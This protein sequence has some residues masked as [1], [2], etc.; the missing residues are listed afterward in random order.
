MTSV[1]YEKSSIEL[2]SLI[3]KSENRFYIV[4]PNNNITS[5]TLTETIYLIIY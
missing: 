1:K 2:F 5:I 4:I 3:T